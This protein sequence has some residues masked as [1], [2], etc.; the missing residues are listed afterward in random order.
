MREKAVELRH[1]IHCARLAE[2][3]VE[4]IPPIVSGAVG[5]GSNVLFPCG[6]EPF[7]PCSRVWWPVDLAA[8]FALVRPS[9]AWTSAQE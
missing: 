3:E 9:L 2:R 1:L 4:G 5:Y 8:A 7:P 6:R